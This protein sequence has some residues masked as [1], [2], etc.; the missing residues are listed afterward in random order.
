MACGAAA[1]RHELT[2]CTAPA[3]SALM[4]GI[5]PFP[6]TTNVLVGALLGR[7]AGRPLFGPRGDAA[8]VR[9]LGTL[10]DMPLVGLS[11]ARLAFVPQWFATAPSHAMP[12]SHSWP[13]CASMA[14]PAPSSRPREGWSSVAQFCRLRQTSS[15]LSDRAQH[16]ALLPKPRRP[17]EPLVHVRARHAPLRSGANLM[18]LS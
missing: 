8:A 9:V 13:N 2:G 14:R 3:R 16:P 17:I 11:T 5:G 18:E 6:R 12:T 7:R 1:A 4:P 10:F 15:R